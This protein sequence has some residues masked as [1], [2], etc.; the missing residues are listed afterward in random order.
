MDLMLAWVLWR[1]QETMPGNQI[2]M[3]VHMYAYVGV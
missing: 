1:V 2:G 3:R